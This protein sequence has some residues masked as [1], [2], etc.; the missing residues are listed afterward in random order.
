MP[1]FYN[2]LKGDMSIVGPRPW[3]PQY[4][5]NFNENQKQRL[6]VKP[7]IIGLAQVN[8]R[9]KINIFEKIDY[10]IKYVRNNNL[11]DDIKI[12]F[13]CVKVIVAKEEYA[14]SEQ[15]ISNEIEL[16]KERNN[17]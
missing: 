1:Q 9:R 2:V 10:D 17:K 14:N 13:K 5:E 15:Y 11:W 4:Y 6:E 16:L 3:I 7:G 8:G 12:I